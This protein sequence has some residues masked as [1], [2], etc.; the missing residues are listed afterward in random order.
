MNWVTKELTGSM[1]KNRGYVWKGRFP[2]MTGECCIEGVKYKIAVWCPKPR[3]GES[4]EAYKARLQQGP[5]GMK[6]EPIK[7]TLPG[8]ENAA[9]ISVPVTRPA[10]PPPAP[11]NRKYANPR[12]PIKDDMAF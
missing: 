7:E 2:S 10:V 9:P 6:F 12:T 5:Y 1:F 3:D 8:H 4:D 11:A